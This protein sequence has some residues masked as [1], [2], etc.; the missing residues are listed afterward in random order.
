M[1]APLDRLGDRKIYGDTITDGDGVGG[2]DAFEAEGAFDFTINQLAIVRQD[3]V[4]AASIF[5]D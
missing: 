5:N 4:P 1:N 2:A 3:G